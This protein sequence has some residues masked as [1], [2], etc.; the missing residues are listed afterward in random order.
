MLTGVV[1]RFDESMVVFEETLKPYFPEI[2]LAYIAQNVQIEK[3]LSRSEKHDTIKEALGESL[4]ENVVSA[5]QSDLELYAY[6]NQ[7]LDQRV[8]NIVDFD[9]KL[10]AFEE[11][12]MILKTK[13]EKR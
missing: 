1:D 13:K 10:L 6:A 8:E 11:R 5:N 2:D 12:C 3:T 9:K 4:F 7:L